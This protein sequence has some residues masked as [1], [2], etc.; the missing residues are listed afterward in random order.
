MDFRR[1]Y[2]VANLWHF[3]LRGTSAVFG[4]G[5][6]SFVCI[7][8]SL[9]LGCILGIERLLRFGKGISILSAFYFASVT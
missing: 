2:I 6:R 9:F 1:F 8:I 4:R 3:L 5:L 7:L